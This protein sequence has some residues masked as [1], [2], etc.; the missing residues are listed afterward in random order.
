MYIYILLL[1]SNGM[2]WLDIEKG[3]DVLPRLWIFLLV[4]L[5]TLISGVIVSALMS[6]ILQRRRLQDLERRIAAGEVDLEML[7]V[8]RLNV[9]Q[10]IL[11]KMPLYTYDDKRG[12]PKP[13][14]S[15]STSQS[16]GE[17]SSKRIEA[18]DRG[19]LAI[20]PHSLLKSWNVIELTMGTSM[21]ITDTGPATCADQ[22]ENSQHLDPSYSQSTCA[23]CLD[24]YVSGESTVRELPCHHIFHPEC[25]DLFLLQNSS[26][27]P[28]CK[29]SALPRGYCP[30]EITNAMVHQERIA[31]RRQQRA[32]RRNGEGERS[33]DSPEQ[34]TTPLRRLSTRLRR[35]LGA[36]LSTSRSTSRSRRQSGENSGA[37]PDLPPSSRRSS[38]AQARM[39]DHGERL[40]IMRRRALQMLGNERMVADEHREQQESAS[41]CEYTLVANEK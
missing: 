27:C 5:I 38:A 4:L 23:I 9:P 18:Q 33:G 34:L 32:E 30:E 7:H 12:P 29:S 20:T 21:S 35:Q 8:K 6:R 22:I 37:P 3:G 28:V 15:N 11:D 40:E 26:L 16:S 39:H 14:N 36:T 19:M 41:R 1:T 31:R 24:D 25:I 13:D 2:P 17:E 10:S